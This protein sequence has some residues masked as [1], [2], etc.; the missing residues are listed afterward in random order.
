[1]DGANAGI[2][3]RNRLMQIGDCTVKFKRK[4]GEKCRIIL[5]DKENPQFNHLQVASL[6]SRPKGI[7]KYNVIILVNGLPMVQ[8]NLTKGEVSIEG[9]YENLRDGEDDG[10]FE[11]IQIFAISNGI[12]TKYFS[13]AIKSKSRDGQIHIAESWGYADGGAPVKEIVDFAHTFLNKRTLLE[14][15][16]RYCVLD[17][18]GNLKILRSY[19][20]AAIERVLHHIRESISSNENNSGI[21]GY[22]WHANG[23]G[24]TLTSFKVTQLAFEIPEVKKVLFVIDKKDL[25]NQTYSQYKNFL[26]KVEDQAIDNTLDTKALKR[27]IND[28][29]RRIIVT[30]TQKL[31]RLLSEDDATTEETKNSR[32][33]IIADE[34]HRNQTP[35]L[36][37]L[38]NRNFDS[39]N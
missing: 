29:T 16:A 37:E 33:V 3:N 27:V 24:K 17:S 23:T 7:G 25:N 8:I 31:S 30:T 2:E 39:K 5:F 20:V 28:D 34:C 10:L 22:I 4:S 38:I 11:F 14:I 32:I 9:A 35:R 13:N 18:S 12:D 6:H 19:Q 1:M 21:G 26:G 36:K 15:L